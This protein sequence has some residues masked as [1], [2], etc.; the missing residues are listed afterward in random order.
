MTEKQKSNSVAVLEAEVMRLPTK[1][2]ATARSIANM[3]VKEHNLPPLVAIKALYA[4]EKG[5][6]VQ[7]GIYTQTLLMLWGKKF[8]NKY[9]L[10]GIQTGEEYNSSLA[11]KTRHPRD[12]RA[13]VRYNGERTYGAWVAYEEA[14]GS[15]PTWRQYPETMMA[16]RAKAIFIRQNF[17]QCLLGLH[18]EHELDDMAKET[19]YEETRK[20]ALPEGFDDEA[21]EN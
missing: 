1:A 2:Q 16:Y 12:C 15:S 4:I 18:T 8:E 14:K 10:I 21:T 9:G 19:T 20:E 3:F 11:Q 6:K 5:G 13:Y 7:I 17:P